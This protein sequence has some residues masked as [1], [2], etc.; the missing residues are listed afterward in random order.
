MTATRGLGRVFGLAL[1]A[2]LAASCDPRERANPFDPGNPDTGGA[3]TVLQALSDDGAVDLRWDVRSFE[4]VHAVRLL[5]RPEGG[6]E[7]IAFVFAGS[8]PDATT[9]RGL[10]NGQAWHYRLEVVTAPASV[11][12]A[13]AIATPG[14]SAP[15]I[16]DA[17]AG[18]AARLTPDGRGVRFRA[19]PGRDLLDLTMEEDGSLWAAD[20]GYGAVVRIDRTGRRQEEFVLP[21]ASTVALDAA[22][23]T[24]WVGSFD[25]RAVFHLQRDGVVRWTDPAAGLIERVRAAPQGGVWAVSRDRSVSFLFD[26]EVWF[27]AGDMAEPVGL[28]VDSLGRAWVADP[29]AG[30]VY[31]IWPGGFPIEA[32]SAAFQTPRDVEPD[33][34]GGAWVADSGR[35]G[36]VHLDDSLLEQTF[37]P[38]AGARGLAWDAANQR[39]WVTRPED[40][41]VEVFAV[42]AGSRAEEARL[43]ASCDLGGRPV[44]VRGIWRR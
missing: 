4:D 44:V 28:A 42:S 38:C 21:G 15:W 30:V 11:F 10:A 8:G 33:G 35:G 17:R 22:D 43:L 9:D 12:S 39:L 2:G 27:R 34:A 29:A 13:E 16:A 37:V 3:P 19:E 20:Y 5:R 26:D 18:G 41:R 24:L 23:G 1:L 14:G 31:R 6:A 40:G 7:E 32:S 36:V 25:Q